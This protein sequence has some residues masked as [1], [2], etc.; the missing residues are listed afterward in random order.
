M[1]KNAIF[2]ERTQTINSYYEIKINLIGIPDI[3][4]SM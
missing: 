1:E 3:P 4:G 2:V